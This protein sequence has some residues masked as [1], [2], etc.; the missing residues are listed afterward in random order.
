MRSV[1]RE[2][3]DN[4]VMDENGSFTTFFFQLSKKEKDQKTK[5]GS[6]CLEWLPSQ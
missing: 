4:T 6:Q 2:V 3:H 5:P 1:A